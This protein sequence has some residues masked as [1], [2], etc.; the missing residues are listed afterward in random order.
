MTLP[1]RAQAQEMFEE[2]IRL[3]NINPY[4]F[5]GNME[6]NFRTHCLAVAEAAEK[7][8]F[9]CGMDAE[10]AYVLGLLH[11]CG[12]IKDEPNEKVFHGQ[13]GYDYMMELGYSEIARISITHC[14]YD[15]DFDEKGYGYPPASYPRSR[16]LL[17]WIEFNDYDRLLHLTDLTNDMG[18]ICTLEYRMES[19]S[20][21]YNIPLDTLRPHLKK[22][23]EIKAYFD[24]KAGTDIYQLLGIKE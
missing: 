12:R 8:A 9:Y 14:F 5:T 20:K 16:E 23:Q 4:P 13:V 19:V 3:R 18:K 2:V 7:I 6:H 10:K 21:R 15:I 11:D 22:L 24:A 17:K 1:N